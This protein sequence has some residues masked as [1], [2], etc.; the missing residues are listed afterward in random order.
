MTFHELYTYGHDK[1]GHSEYWISDI[2][3]DLQ[4]SYKAAN[5]LILAL[6]YY[7]HKLIKPISL[8][9]FQKNSWVIYIKKTIEAKKS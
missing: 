3:K 6:G 4:I 5:H 9:E 1:Y 8:N 7:R 2:A